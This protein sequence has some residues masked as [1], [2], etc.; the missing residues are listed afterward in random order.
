M[1]K[2][3]LSLIQKISNTKTDDRQSLIKKTT[4][5]GIAMWWFI[6]LDI[7]SNFI[8]PHI[9]S[10]LDQKK[11]NLMK[12]IDK[13]KFPEYFLRK[14]SFLY[15]IYN[16]V[17][18]LISKLNTKLYGSGLYNS[19]GKYRRNR[20]LAVAHNINWRKVGASSLNGRKCDVFLDSIISKLKEQ[21]EKDGQAKIITT[22]HLGNPLSGFKI[23][24]D[25]RK[26]QEGVIHKPFNIYWSF[27]IWREGIRAK[28]Y[29]SRAWN[30]LEN[31]KKFKKNLK[32]IAEKEGIDYDFL[33]SKLAFYFRVIF[34]QM[35]EYIKMLRWMIKKEKPNL[36]LII[37]EYDRFGRA[38]TI[39]ARLESIPVLAIQHGIIT[40]FHRG[41]IYSK[42]EISSTG[43]I[44]S[45]YCPIPDR[46]AVYGPYFKNLLTKVST[47]PEDSVVVTGQPRY[48]IL[49]RANKIYSKEKFLKRYKINPNHKIILWL[50]QCHGISEEENIKN[51]KAVF[52]A[53]Q[54]IKDITLVIKQHPGEKEMHAE[55]IKKHLND[56]KINVII[57][58]K[59]SDT[60]EQL[61][62]C[63][64]MVTK[65]STTAMEAVALNK[66]V[67]IL[68]LSEGSD[69]TDYVEQGIACGV[70]QEEDLALAIEKLLKDDSELA[71]G[72]Q[73]FIRE[74]LYKIDGG[75]TKRVVKLIKEMIY[76]SKNQK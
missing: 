31:D 61:F 53:I 6:D 21:K 59:E 1:S 34:G 47:Y 70:Y 74:H 45:P 46:I 39:A 20:I 67:V 38:I 55:M 17:A 68:N 10:L 42:D 57:T 35:V 13:E 49:A 72:R 56:Y 5:Q 26:N 14:H 27:N 11:K 15:L 8:Y 65:H 63:D 33:L 69:F 44:K 3:F 76:E 25:K 24:V 50:T 58:L 16:L 52:R 60:Y 19:E 2:D 32:Q 29:F 23:I 12:E 37:D 71:R 18:F 73:R 9:L 48:D 30:N 36:V 4:Y 28:K 22:F 40:P 51:F 43:S 54:S 66:P 62:V 64:L 41:Y 75:A 7:F